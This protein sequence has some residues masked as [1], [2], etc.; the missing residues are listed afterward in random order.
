MEIE[1]ETTESKLQRMKPLSESER[2]AVF[3]SGGFSKA[4]A[5]AACEY[6]AAVVI[7]ARAYKMPLPTVER[8]A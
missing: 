2:M 4:E 7:W 6:G 5:R 3:M 8:P 1:M